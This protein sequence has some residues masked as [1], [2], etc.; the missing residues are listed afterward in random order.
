MTIFS[1]VNTAAVNILFMI[2]GFKDGGSWSNLYWPL[3]YDL[4]FFGYQAIAFYV[5]M[6]RA[7]R[8]Y[9]WDEEEYYTG[10]SY[11]EMADGDINDM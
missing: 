6:P 5:S 8:F 3:I 4:F 11:R 7:A 2:G 9:K 10:N 1:W